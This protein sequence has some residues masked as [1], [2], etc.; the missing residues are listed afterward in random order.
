MAAPRRGLSKVLH[1]DSMSIALFSLFGVCLAAQSVSGWMGYN[2]ELKDG[3]F[4]LIGWPAYLAT[5]DFLDGM[6][7]NWQAAVLQLAV[8]IAFGTVLHQKGAA[9]SRKLADENP[10][11]LNPRTGAWKFTPRETLGAWISAN[12]LSRVFFGSFVVVFVLHAVCGAMHN[13]EQLRL[14][15]LPPQAFGAYVASAGFW[16]TV[17]QCWEAEF[18]AIGVYIVLSIFLRQESSPESKPVGSSN[19]ET[20]ETNH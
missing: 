14:R 18:F 3:G 20:G 2:D 12:S 5:G 9:H 10:E 17:F 11:A 4:P 7:S 15:H 8:L 16:V 6:F 19:A 13:D 1:D